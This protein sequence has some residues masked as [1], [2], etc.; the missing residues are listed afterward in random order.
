MKLSKKNA[1]RQS[2]IRK[3]LASGKGLGGLLVGLATAVVGGCSER[4][5]STTMGDYP[6]PEQPKNTASETRDASVM[7]KMILKDDKKEDKP[8]KDNMFVIFEGPWAVDTRTKVL[9]WLKAHQCK[10]GS[11]RDGDNP[12]ASTALA[13]LAYLSRGECPGCSSSSKFAASAADHPVALASEYLVGYVGKLAAAQG[14]MS[15]EDETALPIVA[16]ALA[17]TYGMTK[18]PNLKESAIESMKLV[19]ERNRKLPD[20]AKSV[21]LMDAVMWSALALESGKWTKIP[22]EGLVEC[23]AGL[24]NYLARCDCDE[25][26]YYVGRRKFKAAMRRVNYEKIKKEIDAWRSWI[27][28]KIHDCNVAFVEEPSGGTTGRRGYFDFPASSPNSTGLGATAD[29]ALAVL[30]LMIGG[31]G[32]RRLP[33]IED[34]PAEPEDDPDFQPVAVDI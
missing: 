22:V 9:Y 10:D 33:S 24:T 8:M 6:A 29:S 11:W 5:P 21:G 31:G 34:G 18:N 14:K 2:A 23:H 13:V 32:M 20:E 16:R 30:E 25:N 19:V 1:A 26:S 7:G 12:A 3:A 27:K 4:S 28:T 17:E 15:Q